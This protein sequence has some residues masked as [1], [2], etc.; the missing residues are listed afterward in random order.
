M[1]CNLF[2][3]RGEKERM[4]FRKKM[5]DN[6]DSNRKQLDY[7]WRD[8]TT[9]VETLTKE[10]AAIT[11]DG[12]SL[13]VIKLRHGAIDVGDRYLL[14]DPYRFAT[15]E[16]LFTPLP[17]PNI[18][19]IP[20]P[21]VI[22]LPTDQYSSWYLESEKGQPSLLENELAR[23]RKT[24]AQVDELRARI[25]EKRK[26]FEDVFV[27]ETV[28]L[29]ELRQQLLA[30]DPEAIA[31]L[32]ELANRRNW[33]PAGL[34]RDFK[35]WVD[36]EAKVVLTE[37]R[38][39]DYSNYKFAIGELKNG[40]PKYASATEN[41]RILRGTLYSIV[42][43][44]GYIASL[45]LDGTS[46]QTVAVNVVQ[47][48]FDRATGAP[49][50]G[51]ICSLQAQSSDLTGLNLTQ[52]DPEICFKHLKGISVPSM[53]TLSPIR[54]I[55]I[56]NKNDERFVEGRDLREL[57]ET[58]QN[59]AAM[60]WEDFEHLVAQLFE[61]EFAKDGIEVRVTRA[62]RDRGVDAILF[63]PDPLRGGKFV[64]QAKR[65]TNPVDVA[66][67]RDL[68]GTV[69]NEGANRGILITTSSYGPDSY[70]FAKNKPLSL[71]DGP[72]LLQMLQRHGRKFRLDLV[73]ARRLL[74]EM[75]Q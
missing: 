65:Y 25:E 33:L 63:D 68:Y 13:P 22:Q 41:K 4:L 27:K 55:F 51:V 5:Y 49:R 61:W 71:V 16:N 62:S 11:Y 10:I 14:P 45:V 7:K 15:V 20:K 43:R 69:M 30:E 46:Y 24:L 56:L 57:L 48:W 53:E 52:V 29:Q 17:V 34:R 75:D 67:V 37:L 18:P 42:I 6:H 2:G 3:L 70:E 50:S 66:A 1:G 8:F 44:S 40:K 74:K 31:M 38:F 26:T 59:L 23:R 64:L 58:E 9:A 21:P 19:E 35:A 12:M 39:P 28:K 60:P 54:P 36:P 47:D 72:N 73:E 32:I